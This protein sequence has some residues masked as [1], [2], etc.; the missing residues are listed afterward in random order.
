M[1]DFA[2]SSIQRV[3]HIREL[4]WSHAE[5]VLARQAFDLALCNELQATIQ[6]ATESALRRSK[7]PPNYGNSKA[8]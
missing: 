8:G 2:N 1:A 5:K 7:G 4:K 3:V 6:E